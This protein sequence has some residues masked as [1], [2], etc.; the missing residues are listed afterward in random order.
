MADNGTVKCGIDRTKGGAITWLSWQGSPQNVV[1]V[2][3]PGRLIQQSYYAGKPLDRKAD[4][5]HKA[6]SPWTWNPIQG[7]GIGS[8]A[9]VTKLEK[10]ADGLF[11]ETI[12]KLWDMPN[13]EATAVMRQWTGFEPGMPNVVVVRCEFESQREPG[14]RWGPAVPRHQELPACYFTRR[15]GTFK[16][17]LGGGRWR[18]ESQPPGPPWGRAKPPRNAMACFDTSGQGIAVFSPAATGT[19]NFGP[20]GDGESSD[21]RAAPC[22]HVAPLETV[23]LEPEAVIRYRYWLVVGTAADLAQR[24][25]ALWTAHAAERLVVERLDDR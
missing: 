9:R 22:V 14:D 1:N 10:T 4:G 21:P 12:P 3:D 2:V 25:D 13:E 7:G 18:D 20:H 24:L 23:K 16:S 19:W 5:Q 8:W 6:W 17:Y 11:C 15:F